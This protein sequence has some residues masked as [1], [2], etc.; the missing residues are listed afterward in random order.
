MTNS[1]SPK[2]Q[3]LPVEDLICF[4][5]YSATHAINKVYKPHLDALGL[6]YPQYITLMALWQQDGVPV[7]TL[8]EKLHLET[9][10]MTPLLKRLEKMG[11][12]TR[13]RSTQDERKVLVHLTHSGH[14]LSAAVPEI[15][16][17]VMDATGIPISD[18]EKLQAQVMAMRDQLAQIKT[19]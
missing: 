2:A 10:T 17:C 18:L 16:T 8:C 9:N 19:D 7:S 12:V 3:A 5:L 6:T 14:A 4:A 13:K 1:L 15:T 11:H